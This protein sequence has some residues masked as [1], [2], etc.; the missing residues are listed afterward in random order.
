MY[1]YFLSPMYLRCKLQHKEG[2]LPCVSL[3]HYLLLLYY[4]ALGISYYVT[5]A[6]S[7]FFL[8]VSLGIARCSSFTANH[9]VTVSLGN[10][11][12]YERFHISFS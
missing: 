8:V 11:D 7:H 1:P 5:P 2:E 3:V 10:E 4:P 9:R 12:K 6:V